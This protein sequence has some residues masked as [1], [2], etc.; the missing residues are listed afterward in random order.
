MQ[1]QVAVQQG[2]TT[3]FYEQDEVNMAPQVRTSHYSALVCVR[4]SREKKLESC[5]TER[6]SEMSERDDETERRRRQREADTHVT[7]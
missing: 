5:A 7:Q 1:E 2:G 3:F 6:R 4:E